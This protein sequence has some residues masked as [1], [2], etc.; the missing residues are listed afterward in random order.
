MDTLQARLSKTP[1]PHI[2]AAGIDRSLSLDIEA[3]EDQIE[4]V[5]GLRIDT[6]RQYSSR[7][8]SSPATMLSDLDAL[9]D[10][11]RFVVGHNLTAYDL[12]ELGRHEPELR[13]LELAP[14][15]TLVLSPIAFPQR[16]Y[17]RLVKHYKTPGLERFEVNDPLLDARTAAALLDEIC[18]A[19]TKKQ[20]SAPAHLRAWH[21][22]LTRN[23]PWEGYDTLFTHVR[24]A[25]IPSDEEG[26]YAIVAALKGKGC[27]Q[28]AERIA[29]RAVGVPLPTAWL[30]AWTSVA[31]DGSSS[32]IPPYVWHRAPQVRDMV[33]ALRMQRCETPGCEWCSERLDPEQQLTRWLG[34]EGFNPEPETEEGKSVQREIVV[35]HLAEVPLLAVMPT[36]AGKSLCYQLP[37]LVRHAGSA[38]LTVVISPLVALMNDQVASMKRRGVD[39]AVTI[40]GLLTAPERTAALD[41]IVYGEA[42]IVLLAPE[43]LRT[44]PVRRALEQR[45]IGAWVLDEAHCVS[46]WGH[47]FRPD[48]RYVSRFMHERHA[49]ERLPAVLAL[50][51]TAKRSVIDDIQRHYESK[52]GIEMDVIDAGGHRTNLDFIVLEKGKGDEA[53]SIA[54]L[55]N[56]HASADAEGSTIIYC[57]TQRES[58]VLADSLR[59]RDIEARAFH[60]SLTPE[61]KKAAMEDFMSGEVRTMV[62]TKAFGMGVDKADVRH[63]VHSS[64]P[65]SIE[66]YLQEA[67]RAGRDREPARCILLF[68]RKDIERQLRLSARGRVHPPDVKATLRALRRMRDHRNRDRREEHTEV[69]TTTREILAESDEG[70]F[71]DDDL[72]E[73]QMR[74]VLAQLEETELVSQEEHRVQIYP[75]SVKVPTVA[76]AERRIDEKARSGKIKRNKVKSLKDVAG[77]LIRTPPTETL[78]TD[79]VVARTGVNWRELRSV[80]A[81]LQDLGIVNNDINIT[82]YVHVG[83]ARSSEKRLAEAS[84]AEKA[85]IDVLREEAPDDE[86][87][88]EHATEL[89][90]RLCA[91]RVRERTERTTLPEQLLTALRSLA[92]DGKGEENGKGGLWVRKT[93]MDGVRVRL[94]RTWAD[95]AATAEL[96]RE[97]ARELLGH[98]T[99][100]VA[101]TRGGDLLVESTYGE[102]EGVVRGDVTLLAQLRSEPRAVVDRALLWMHE[103]NVLTLNRGMS[104][105]RRS[106]TLEV[107]RSKRQYRNEDHQGLAIHY[108]ATTAQIHIIAEYARLA[109]EKGTDHAKR[110]ADDYFPLDTEAFIDKWLHGQRDDL[111]R[112]TLPEHYDAIVYALG[113]R[114]QR[115]VVTDER[116]LKN[117]LV[118]AGPG[119]GKTRVLV[120]RIAFLVR[121]L[122]T[123]PRSILALAYNRHAAVEIRKRLKALIGDDAR[124][125]DVAT[126]HAF[127]MRI[128]GRAPSEAAR[129]W[130]DDDF[131]KVLTEASAMLNEQGDTGDAHDRLLQHYRYVLVDEYQDIGEE[132]Y[133]F[134][135]AVAGK[136]FKDEDARIQLLAVGDDDQ[137]IYSFKGA[138]VRYIRQFE[139][140][141]SASQSNLPENYRST[142]NIIEASAAVITECTERMKVGTELTVNR[143]RMKDPAGG[144]WQ[145]RDVIGQGRVQILELAK[146][147][148]RQD[149]PA[150]A[151]LERLKTLDTHFDWSR[152]AVIGR[153]WSDV[154]GIHALCRERHIPVQRGDDEAV[155]FW[156]ARETQ[157]MLRRLKTHGETHVPISAVVAEAH[158]ARADPWGDLVREAIEAWS[159]EEGHSERVAFAS[160]TGWLHEW[161]RDLRRA[162]RGLLLTTAHGAK[163]L[164]FDHV[165]I[166]D[167]FWHGHRYDED[168]DV[169]R[170]LYYVA[171]TRARQ[172]LALVHSHN[173]R[174]TAEQLQRGL[175][176]LDSVCLR[177]IRVAE[178][179]QSAPR[180]RIRQYG[181]KD[182]NI[183]YAGYWPETHPVHAALE[184]AQPGDRI[185]ITEKNGQF[186]IENEQR[187]RIGHMSKRFKTNEADSGVIEEARI[188]GV[189]KWRKDSSGATAGHKAP[190]VGEWEVVVPEICWK[191]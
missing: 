101:G 179:I 24:E 31:D 138:S 109:L 132:E 170:R 47:D 137:N 162:Q 185:D 66:D 131:K 69:V 113:S 111:K 190:E 115:E 157:A 22:L 65:G 56:G 120:H 48:Y 105:L 11:A 177:G 52:L 158:K 38:E 10:G 57:M 135:A 45:V 87:L 20:E 36:G 21:W 112:Q 5:A 144:T 129:K 17:H 7:T 180:R 133:D 139:T 88:K 191:A 79:D 108:E 188:R 140:D 149:A 117:V 123:S 168:P 1:Y 98:L 12:P 145:N 51:A 119:S 159:E 59:E 166:L 164:E 122:R 13:L 55:L 114:R 30:I 9:G 173:A 161:S 67:G 93:S 183:G 62:A 73:T 99:G 90:L 141:Y 44:R 35:R 165:V 75:A 126:C 143:A 136:S 3:D 77:L 29:S 76:D 118:L 174:F 19:L 163:G 74:V 34:F 189:F 184:Q 186:Y 110:M 58:E 70:I 125:V 83:V 39:C 155:S 128:M 50:T 27:P 124:G 54:S 130:D 178:S 43:S 172:T 40:N 80:C 95:I 152:C 91:E 63:V 97:A 181:L 18:E 96:R 85:L 142:K 127:A 84:E 25:A 15:D 32:V 42:G 53:E 100:K 169:A 150:L 104:M 176:S 26:K 86:A 71:E 153:H 4:S 148:Y 89:R 82:A 61:T 37:A 107:A 102:L 64:V 171:M 134:I 175:S 151:E 92:R 72:A 146:A 49:G 16:P 78:T 28:E 160:L 147:H 182:V 2:Q 121:V 14:I 68:D 94:Q 46:Q 103:Q 41:Q 156:H 81:M 33:R 8:S 60:A 154:E 6:A 106:H 116:T 187:R 167:G 23:P